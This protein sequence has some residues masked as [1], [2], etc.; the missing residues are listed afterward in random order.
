[1]QGC[2]LYIAKY[3]LD[4]FVH[5]HSAATFFRFSFQINA[6]V[7]CRDLKRQYFRQ[8]NSVDEPQCKREYMYNILKFYALIMNCAFEATPPWSVDTSPT[9]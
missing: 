3:I 1:M 5:Y 6:T 2:T 9:C 8:H 4:I 7:P